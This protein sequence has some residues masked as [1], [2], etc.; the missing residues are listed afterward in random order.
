MVY[1]IKPKNKSHNYY[2]NICIHGISCSQCFP[3]SQTYTGICTHSS[4]Q[5]TSHMILVMA[6]IVVLK[7][8]R[9][10]DG[11]KEVEGHRPRMLWCKFNASTLQG[12]TVVVWKKNNMEL[13]NSSRY[14]IV[15]SNNPESEDLVVSTLTINSSDYYGTYSCYCFY[16]NSLVKS[17]KPITSNEV[18][19]T[20]KRG[21]SHTV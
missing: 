18:S 14:I 13:Q 16:N 4:I 17:T 19:I 7:L 20:F 11:P 1:F 3:S 2:V 9:I 10:I 5:T 21:K 12:T 8:P 15:Q 6:L